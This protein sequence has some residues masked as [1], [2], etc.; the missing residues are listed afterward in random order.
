MQVERDLF[1]LMSHY[2]QSP[3]HRQIGVKQIT[4]VC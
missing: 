4:Y 2:Y 3:F 1:L